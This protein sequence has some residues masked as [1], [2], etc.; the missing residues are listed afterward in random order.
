MTPFLACSREME[1][2]KALGNIN[3][4]ALRAAAPWL[5]PCPSI[6]LGGINAQLVGGAS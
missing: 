3:E 6:V 2:E 1:K 5:Q 4:A